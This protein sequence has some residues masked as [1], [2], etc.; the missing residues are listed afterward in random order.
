M[1]I[2]INDDNLK[3]REIDEFSS[4]VRAL[5]IEDDKVLIANYGNVFLLPGGKIEEEETTEEAL[6][7]EVEE[8]T[9]EVYLVEDFE[10]LNTIY[11]FQR[12][13][14]TREGTTI[15]RLVKTRFFIAPFRGID[16]YNLYLTEGEQK[17]AFT[18]QLVPFNELEDMLINHQTDNPRNKYFTKELL[19]IIQCYK[20]HQEQSKK[21]SKTKNL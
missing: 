10:F 20:K 8:E 16:E 12:N 21:K 11:Y 3:F 1:S 7:R 2:K 6:L 19:T 9:G 18:L 13:Y 14:P 15:N 4:K 17:D 5:L